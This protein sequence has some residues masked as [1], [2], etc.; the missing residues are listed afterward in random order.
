V[1]ERPRDGMDLGPVFDRLDL[2]DF[3]PGSWL[4]Q[5]EGKR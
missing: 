4:T 2:K 5:K 1:S 3:V